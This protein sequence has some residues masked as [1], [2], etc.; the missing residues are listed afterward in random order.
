VST[1]SNWYPH[2]FDTGN[3]EKIIKLEMEYGLEGSGLYHRVLEHMGTSNG[4]S[5]DESEI[6]FIAKRNFCTIENP[7]KVFLALKL[8]SVDNKGQLFSKSLRARLARLDEKHNKRVIAGRKGGKKKS[9]NARA[10]L[11]DSYKQKDSDAL[12][13][14]NTTLDKNTEH[15]N[16]E[17]KRKTATPKR[18]LIENKID[19]IKQELWEEWID[20]KRKLKLGLTGRA[21]KSN[22]NKLY[23]FG[24]QRANELI[25][26]AIDRGWKDIYDPND[27]KFASIGKP[28]YQVQQE[29]NQRAFNKRLTS[30]GGKP[31]VEV[32]NSPEEQK[33][34]DEMAANLKRDLGIKI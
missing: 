33:K 8:F 24:T 5:L 4:H 26:F 18:F 28:A 2:D 17:T 31:L 14:H 25:T 3:D 32:Q 1:Y 23:K 20:H 7:A 21:L 13:L 10:G 16:K 30:T 29:G 12:A 9:S 6:N 27:N 34:I 15:K 19:W 22:V 11:V